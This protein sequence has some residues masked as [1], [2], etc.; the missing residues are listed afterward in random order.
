MSGSGGRN[1]GVMMKKVW[2]ISWR[3]NRCGE[4]STHL[5]WFRLVLGSFSFATHSA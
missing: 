4:G 2:K 3:V 5:R 1:G